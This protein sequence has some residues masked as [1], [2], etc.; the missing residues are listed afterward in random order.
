MTNTSTMLDSLP[1]RRFTFYGPRRW[2]HV[3]GAGI[4]VIST[5]YIL[6]LISAVDQDQSPGDVDDARATEPATVD[7]P[8]QERKSPEIDSSHTAL[9]LDAETIRMRADKEG[10]IRLEKP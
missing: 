4:T 5:I 9:L 8:S 7:V 6:L 1:S 3:N 2:K 10:N